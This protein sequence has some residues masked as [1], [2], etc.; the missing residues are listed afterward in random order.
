MGSYIGSGARGVVC[1]LGF[2]LVWAFGLMVG[3][4]MGPTNGVLLCGLKCAGVLLDDLSIIMS[5]WAWWE[6]LDLV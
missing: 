3:Q 4:I 1:V 6:T 5:D 2:R